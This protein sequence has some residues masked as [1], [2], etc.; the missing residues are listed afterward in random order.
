MLRSALC[1]G[2][3]QIQWYQSS[4]FKFSWSWT[5]FEQSS[6]LQQSSQGVPSHL[7]TCTTYRKY[8]KH[9]SCDATTNL[10]PPN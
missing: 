5:L 3:S 7:Y 8:H 6:F 2:R 9:S 1:G 10:Q 4:E